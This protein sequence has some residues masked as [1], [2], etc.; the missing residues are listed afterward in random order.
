M[1]FL[2]PVYAGE[3]LAIRGAV[4]GETPEADGVRLAL[5]VWVED[6]A[7]AMTAAGWASAR[8]TD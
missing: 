8:V 1:K 6:S 7:G 4:T 2:K 5:E 3:R